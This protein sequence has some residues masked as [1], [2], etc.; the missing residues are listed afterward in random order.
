M[1]NGKEQGLSDNKNSWIGEG[2]TFSPEYV[3]EHTKIPD[4][5]EDIPN[6]VGWA[7]PARSGTTA[8]LLLAASQTGVDR[9]YF[10]PQRTLIRKGAPDFI[11]SSDDKFICM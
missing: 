5:K 11:V 4:R 9:A 3:I 2:R 6:I 10:Q 8:L 1:A 7:G